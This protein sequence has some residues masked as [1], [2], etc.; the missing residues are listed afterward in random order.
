MSEALF[1]RLLSVEDKAEALAEAIT[2]TRE[3]IALD[4]VIHAV[5]PE[6]FEQVPGSPFAYWVSERIRDVFTKFSIFEDELRGRTTRCGLGTLDDFQFLRLYWEVAPD[7]L[8]ALWTPYYHGGIY[9]PVYDDFPMVVRWGKDGSQIKAFVESKVGSASRKVQG[10]DHYFLPGFVFPRRTRAFSPKIMPSGG[11]YSTAGQAGFLPNDDLEWGIA[12]LSSAICNFLISLSQGTTSQELGG[13]N[14]Q[15]EVGLVK[16]L[17]WPE[18]GEKQKSKLSEFTRKIFHAKRK[19]AASDETSYA[20]HLPALLQ[21]TGHTLNQLFTSRNHHISEVE[22]Q[23]DEF[24]HEVN[25]IAFHLYGIEGADRQAI[26]AVLVS[27]Q[28]SPEDEE[29]GEESASETEA[30]QP[31]ADH[32]QLTAD[33]LSYFVGC[34]FGRW[35]VHYATGERSA[36]ELTDPFAPLPV[37]APGALTGADGSPLRKSPSG[38]PLRVD[39]DG[40]LVD[41]PD[42]N[43]DIIRRV[44]EVF[45]LLWQKRAEEIEHE[46]CELLSVK[47]LRDYFRKPAAG[48]FWTDHIKRYS[49]S[50]RK[51]PIYWLLQS[52]KKSYSLWLYYHRLDKDILFKALLNYVEPKLRLEESA[53]SQLRAGRTEVGAAGKAAKQLE[54]QL[55]RQEALLSELYDFRDK[56][57]RAA[58]LNLEPDLND[59]VVLNIAP[60][61]ELVP[62]TEAKK[63]WNE[64]LE[65]KYEWSSIGKQL[66]ERGLVEK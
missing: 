18:A 44:R 54:K 9:S 12:I 43:D 4:S 30:E 31:T 34:A 52:S 64:L 10:E 25:N 28:S 1:L 63:Y 47:T 46:A 66:R 27:S 7:T 26:E 55:E 14:P 45:E 36:P 20:Y 16:R 8:K 49:K 58:D 53:L 38:Y 57:K 29:V 15:F 56:L 51:A 33:L 48:G 42:H 22:E 3:G 41:D 65:G 19:L 50:R 40:I 17:P 13:T 21:M 6:A 23:L 61:W 37:C 5:D 24:R 62:W 35:D 11:I 2:A 39:W 59:G 32:R 60:L